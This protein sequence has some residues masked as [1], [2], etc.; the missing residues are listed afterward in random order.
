[1]LNNLQQIHITLLQKKQFKKK[2]EATDDL[3]VIK[4]LIKLQY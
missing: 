4:L 2:T 3:I 1:M